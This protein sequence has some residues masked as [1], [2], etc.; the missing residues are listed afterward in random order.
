VQ[1]DLAVILPGETDEAGRFEKFEE[2][3]RARHGVGD[4]HIRT[5]AGHRELCVH[6][7]PAHVTVADMLAFARS[8]GTK[9]SKRY[10]SKS[11]FVREM[12]SAQCATTIEHALRRTPGILQADV[13]YASERLVVEFDSSTIS[14][15]A[16]EKKLDTLGYPLEEPSHGHACS[17]HAH[18]HG[19]LAP[20]LELPL[21]ITSGVLLAA[22]FAIEKLA[23][24]PAQLPTIVYALSLLSGGFFAAKGALTSLLQLKVDIESLMVL[25]AVGA[26]NLGAWFEGAFLLFLFSVG[27]AVEHRA[28]ESARRAVEALGKLRPQTARVR[29]GDQVVEVPVREVKRGDVVVIR[30]GDRV[31]VD[32]LIV[33]GK[34]SLEQAAITGESIPVAKAEGDEVFCGTVNTEAAL[35]V[36]VTK[37]SSESV[38]ARVVDMVVEAE[39]RKSPSQRFAT[40]VEQTFVPIILVLAVLLP[41]VLVFGF[42][43]TVKEAA[44]RAVSLLVAASPCALAI[45]TPA[46]VLSAVAAAARGGVLVKGGVHLEAL[47]R[48]DAVAF[49]KTGTLTIGKPKLMSILPRGSE[50]EASLLAVAAGA[51]ALS[52]HPLA[53]AVVEGA[54]AKGVTPSQASGLEAVHGKGLRA[55]VEG[56]KVVIGNL[57]L[58]EGHPGLDGV[59]PMVESLEAQGQTAMVVEREGAFL[60]VLGVADALRP[61]AKDTVAALHAL[62]VDRTVMLSGDNTRAANAVGSTVGIRDVRAPLMPQGKVDAIKALAKTETVAMVGDGVNDAPALAAATVGIAMGGAGSEVAMETADVVLMADDLQRLP[63]AVKLAKQATSAVRQNLIVSLGVSAVLVIASVLGL[64]QVSEAVVLHEGSTLVVLANGLR[65]LSVRP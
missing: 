30:P 44:L 12:D 35:E 28:M 53:H 47:G 29:R 56:R 14:A 2:L 9:I 22:G 37:L 39:A 6:Y 50:T 41:L 59:R 60:G 64:T 4:A 26:A 58:F 46:A 31:P 13:A 52:A 48:V 7:D 21:A 51:E 27:H 17:I 18:G 33:S 25:A 43:L 36:K 45:S 54:K 34:S 11:W 3:L 62:G 55:I 19:G 40:K 10:V 61:E 1:L 23:V 32:G 65:L 16:I 15:K 63:F 49:D 42:D 38:I 20:K 5:D 8:T 57:A 24:G